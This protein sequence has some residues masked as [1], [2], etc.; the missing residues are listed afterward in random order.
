M[1][2]VTHEDSTSIAGLGIE[3]SGPTPTARTESSCT[4]CATSFF[5]YGVVA[6]GEPVR[7]SRAPRLTKNGNIDHRDCR[8]T[9]SIFASNSSHSF[10]APRY[11]GNLGCRKSSTFPKPQSVRIASQIAQKNV[12][13][14]LRR[15]GKATPFLTFRPC[16]QRKS[17]LLRNRGVLTHRRPPVSG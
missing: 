5:S 4:G 15:A 8:R 12:S 7:T 10:R 1:T 14:S 3:N 9:G 2:L 11:V 16:P 17:S 6:M 13:R